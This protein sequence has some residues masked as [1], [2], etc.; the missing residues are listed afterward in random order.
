[1]SVS[2]LKWLFNSDVCIHVYTSSAY[3]PGILSVCSYSVVTKQRKVDP[4]LD[5]AGM[6]PNITVW[7]DD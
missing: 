6:S 2:V 4:L 3:L 5:T 7:S 1:M